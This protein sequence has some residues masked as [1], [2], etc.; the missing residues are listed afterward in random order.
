MSGDSA[1]ADKVAHQGSSR[2]I[3]PKSSRRWVAFARAADAGRPRLPKHRAPFRCPPTL[4][5]SPTGLVSARSGFRLLMVH[6][7][8]FAEAQAGFYGAGGFAAS[9]AGY[10]IRSGGRFHG[11]RN[12]RIRNDARNGPLTWRVFPAHRAR[13][14]VIPR[15]PEVQ[16]EERRRRA[17]HECE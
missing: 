5:P 14:P 6:S 15:S 7:G 2:A 4:P 12:D 1:A 10:R 8:T 17:Q 3:F 16:P 11:I 13:E 9:L